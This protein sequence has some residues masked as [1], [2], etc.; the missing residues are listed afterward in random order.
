MTTKSYEMQVATTSFLKKQHDRVVGIESRSG[1]VTCF[2]L[3]STKVLLDPRYKDT[4]S[5]KRVNKAV[6]NNKLNQ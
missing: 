1:N 6:R 2:I 3:K 5:R 4:C